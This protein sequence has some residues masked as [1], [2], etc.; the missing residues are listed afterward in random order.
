MVFILGNEQDA[1][2]SEVKIL[3]RLTSEHA[4][5]NRVFVLHCRLPETEWLTVN[6]AP[7]VHT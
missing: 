1:R 3:R 6:G 2:I 7:A 5:I 4:E